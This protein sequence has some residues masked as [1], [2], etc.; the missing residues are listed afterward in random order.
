MKTH[1]YK[2]DIKK[3]CKDKHLTVE[4]IFEEIKKIYSD[5]WKSS[6]YRNVEEMVRDW[7]LRKLVWVWKKAYFESNCGNHVHL[8]DVNTGDIIDL[9]EDIVIKN[10]PDNFEL[11][12]MDVK[13]FGEFIK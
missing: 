8:V 7:E 9:P 5:A 13:L 1:Y 4:E 12:N 2:W 11:K 10:L 3:I 6:I